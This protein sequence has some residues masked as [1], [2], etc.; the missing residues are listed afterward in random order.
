M[1]KVLL[2][3]GLVGAVVVLGLLAAFSAEAP[4]ESSTTTTAFRVEGMTCGG[5]EVA[6]KRAVKKLE[7]VDT[8]AA[9]HKA[10]SAEVT[11]DPE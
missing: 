1:K 2:T 4:E 10:G 7:G 5:C 3:T 11:Y 9:S 8:V 6:V